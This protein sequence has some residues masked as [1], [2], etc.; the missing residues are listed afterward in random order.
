MP[1]HQG[2]WRDKGVEFKQSFTPYRL[3]FPCKQRPLSICESYALASQ[4]LLK[5]PILDLKETQ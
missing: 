1:P 3:R 2:V 5:Q 4:P